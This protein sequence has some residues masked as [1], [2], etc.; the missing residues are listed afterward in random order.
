MGHDFGADFFVRA[1]DA[2]GD[3]RRREEVHDDELTERLGVRIEVLVEAALYFSRRVVV[4]QKREEG[5]RTT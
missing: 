3:L 4:A 1:D 2:Y 5:K